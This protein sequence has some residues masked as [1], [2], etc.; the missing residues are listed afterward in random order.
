VC[1]LFA[2]EFVEVLPSPQSIKPKY[3]P[4]LTYG[5]VMVSLEPVV[6]HT[7]KNDG[8]NVGVGVIV[9]VGV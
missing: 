9:G 5:N 3:I 8:G 7:D 1:V 2:Y 4:V 6:L